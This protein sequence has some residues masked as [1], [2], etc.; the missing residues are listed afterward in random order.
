ALGARHG[1][2]RA[3]LG[4]IVGA[5]IFNYATQLTTAAIPWMMSA[6]GITWASR[7]ALAALFVGWD[8]AVDGIREKI[9]LRL[10][11]GVETDLSFGATTN[12]NV[13]YWLEEVPTSGPLLVVVADGSA[14]S[15][16]A[17]EPE[18]AG[19]KERQGL[20][21]VRSVLGQGVTHR[22]CDDGCRTGC[23]CH[24]ASI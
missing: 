2:E 6:F 12:A 22:F 9:N 10:S 1:I 5:A 18:L 21:V 16:L 17:D 19:A 7:W 8:D 15:E 11:G 23:C 24:D 14:G 20:G 3:V 13:R 4:A